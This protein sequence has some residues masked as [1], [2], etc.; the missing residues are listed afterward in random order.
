MAGGAAEDDEL[1]DPYFSL[2]SLWWTAED[3]T[4]AAK[5]ATVQKRDFVMIILYF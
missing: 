2:W 5:R 4:V 1:L 3:A